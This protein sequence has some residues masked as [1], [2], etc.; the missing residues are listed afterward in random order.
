MVMSVVL[1]V[2]NE[3]SCTA[4]TTNNRSGSCLVSIPAP[5]DSAASMWVVFTWAAMFRN[6]DVGRDSFWTAPGDTARLRRQVIAGEYRV[7][8]WAQDEGGPGCKVSDVFVALP[9]P[10]AVRFV[11]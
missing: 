10:G 6:G 2:Q 11:R 3:V 1:T 5:R 9:V 8:A 4:P 7:E